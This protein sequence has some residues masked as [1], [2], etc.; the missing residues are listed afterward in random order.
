MKHFLAAATVAVLA[1]VVFEIAQTDAQ[2]N[3]PPLVTSARCGM[4][5]VMLMCQRRCFDCHGRE[6]VLRA[7]YVGITCTCIAIPSTPPP[8]TTSTSTTTT[9]TTQAPTTNRDATTEPGNT[10]EP[11]TTTN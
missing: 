6:R 3:C 11:W 2:E 10:T 5:P 4:L 7:C 8:P 9:T 1:L